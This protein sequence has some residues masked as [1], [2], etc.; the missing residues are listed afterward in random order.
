MSKNTGSLRYLGYGGWALTAALMSCSKAEHVNGSDTPGPAVSSCGA[1]DLAQGVQ[2][3]SARLEHFATAGLASLAGLENSRAAARVLSLGSEHVLE[4]FVAETQADLRESISELRDEQLVSGN[5]ES[6]TGSSITFLIHPETACR[7]EIAPTAPP[8]SG[9]GGAFAGTGGTTNGEKPIGDTPELDPDCVKRFTEH[10][11]RLRLS[12]IACDQGEN[13]AL[14]VF[15]NADRER[16]LLAELYSERAELELNAGLFFREVMSV[17]YEDL[18]DGT[19]H[20]VE[21]P[22]FT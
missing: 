15:V 14:E 7:S 21:K 12:R 11:V 16:L 2:L 13:L 10:P 20:N 5:V 9:S 4:P 3:L 19:G 22:V 8:V 18:P 17:E 6:S 1:L